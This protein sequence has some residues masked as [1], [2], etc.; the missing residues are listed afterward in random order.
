LN[1][2]PIPRAS[3]FF[4]GLLAE[5]LARQQGKR[6]IFAS[7]LLGTLRQRELASVGTKLATE[8][9]LPYHLP[10]E[11]EMSGFVDSN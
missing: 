10:P 11:G 6:F 5:D 7:D 9:G 4:N 2:A 1:H 8:S 3:D